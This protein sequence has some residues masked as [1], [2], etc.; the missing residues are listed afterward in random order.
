MSNGLLLRADLHTLF[1]L[2][3]IAIDVDSLSVLVSP[4]LSGTLYAALEG[5][6]LHQP[7]DPLARPNPI[8]LSAH[9]A[10]AKL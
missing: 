1:D 4:S 6:P 2:G 9:R 7:R 5:C 8:A 3:Q 10:W